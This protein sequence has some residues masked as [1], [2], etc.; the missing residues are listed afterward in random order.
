MVKVAVTSVTVLMAS[1]VQGLVSVPVMLD[2]KVQA[3]TK[4]CSSTAQ[5]T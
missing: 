1:A 2:S 4:V 3:V 5:P